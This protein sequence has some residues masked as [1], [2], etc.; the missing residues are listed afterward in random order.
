M[1]GSNPT[2]TFVK[3]EEEQLSN[4]QNYPMIPLPPTTYD[5]HNVSEPIP[6]VADDDRRRGLFGEWQVARLL[7]GCRARG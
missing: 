7:A 2:V 3:Q 1:E 6:T 4:G 5:L